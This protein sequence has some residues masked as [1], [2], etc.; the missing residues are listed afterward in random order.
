MDDS[1]Q[2]ESFRGRLLRHRGRTSLIQRDLAARAGIGLRSLQDWE[3]GV[4]LP[5]AQRL[6]ALIRA[7]EYRLGR[8]TT[9]RVEPPREDPTES[10]VPSPEDLFKRV[11]LG[12]PAAG[13]PA[14]PAL[15]DTDVWD[16]VHFVRAVSKPARLPA[17]VRAKV[18]PGSK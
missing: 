5:S 3:T 17:D 18:I 1:A 12:V 10:G 4:S 14:S 9:S 13:M 2:E 15:S 11:R 6:Q 8:P 7:L 16:L